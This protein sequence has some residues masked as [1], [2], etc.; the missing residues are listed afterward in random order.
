MKSLNQRQLL[1]VMT[2][3]AFAVLPHVSHLSLSV[4]IWFCAVF[5]WRLFGVWRPDR[6]PAALARVVLVVVGIGLLVAFHPDHWGANAGTAV[7]V[8]AL[9]I[10]LLELIQQRDAYLLSYVCLLLLGALFLFRQ[11]VLASAYALT[12]FWLWLSA[13]WALNGK[14]A[15]P[16]IVLRHTGGMLLQ[17]LPITLLLFVLFPRIQPPTLNWLD[18]EHQAKS[19]LSDTLEPGSISQLALSPELAFRVKFDGEVPPRDQLYWRGP[20][21]SFTD[22]KV[23][24]VV[25]NDYALNFQDPLAFSGK[26]IRYTLL[27]EPQKRNWV[28]ALD[29]PT[30][31]DVSV[32]RNANYQLISQRKVG[33]AAEF[34]LVSHPSYNTG[35]ITKIE[36]R[37]NRQLPDEPS[38]RIIELVKQL[39]G[40]DDDVEG[41]M[42]NILD[43]FRQQHFSYTLQPPL[44]EEQPIDRFLFEAKKG[45]CNHF[46]TAFVYLMRV[47][48]IPARVVGGY[49]G[50]EFNQVG[51]FLEVRQANAHA[52][53]EVWLDGKGWVRIDPTATILPA[54]IEQEVNV[55]GQVTTGN[56]SLVSNQLDPEANETAS[57]QIGLIWDSLDYQWQH[58]IVHY[59]SGQQLSLLSLAG[60]NKIE[61][62]LFWVTYALAVV[63]ALLA[64]WI[65]QKRR[66]TD[67][68]AV[69]L[70]RCFCEKMAK[71]GVTIQIGEGAH[72]FAERAKQHLPEQA[73]VIDAVTFTFSKLHYQRVFSH[74]DLQILRS[75][76][77]KITCLSPIGKR[78]VLK[79]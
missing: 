77:K 57:R 75:N 11:D 9:A 32:H 47:A 74:Q 49:Q 72:S 58:W 24:S 51:Q 13:L 71:A 36:Y 62:V 50:G 29:M 15:Q 38:A 60:L 73:D 10:K 65:L 44:M 43:Y 55:S 3:S 64:L 48:D 41:Y 46:A 19:G 56:V 16:K 28:Y 4:S 27:L 33:E 68:P 14:T 78:R 61:A 67:E 8:V 1:W 22:G 59:G 70:Y 12:G 6:L 69:A 39:R 76:I 53:A 42:Q 23:W 52:W 2:V 17:A 20:V 37:Q 34:A 63:M 18:A 7:F 21:F 54:R 26:P 31:Y 25:D 66:K 40:F 35:Y 5:A 79:D 45:F 30:A